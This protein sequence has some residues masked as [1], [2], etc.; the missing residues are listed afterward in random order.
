MKILSGQ[1]KLLQVVRTLH[2]AS[3]LAGGLN[4]WQQKCNQNPNDRNHNQEFDQSKA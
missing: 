3:G 2:P 4:R 1:P